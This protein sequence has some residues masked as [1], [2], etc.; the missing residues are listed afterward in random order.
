[1][2]KRTTKAKPYIAP[3]MAVQVNAIVDIDDE[4]NTWFNAGLADYCQR[5]KVQVMPERLESKIKL[6]LI[7]APAGDNGLCAYEP[8]PQCA[9]VRPNIMIQAR[10]IAL[11]DE[12]YSS[13]S[14]T[15]F[16]EV[17]AHE[18]VHAYQALTGRKG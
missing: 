11:S 18:F 7:Y 9:D 13:Y 6:S 8:R 2:T 10:C 5:F 3:T 4:I 12:G 1:M 16:L 15:M 14:V 17:L